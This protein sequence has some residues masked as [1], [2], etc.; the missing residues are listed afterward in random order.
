MKCGRPWPLWAP[1]AEGV[2]LAPRR[3]QE[4]GTRVARARKIDR[5]LRERGEAPGL[6]RR[7]GAAAS[8]HGCAVSGDFIGRGNEVRGIHADC[9]RGGVH[10]AAA[11]VREGAVSD[12]FIGRCGRG[13]R[14]LRRR[15]ARRRSRWMVSGR[16]C[17]V[18]GDFIGR[19]GR[20]ARDLRRRPARRG[21]RWMASGRRG[22]RFERLHRPLWGEVHGTCADCLRGGV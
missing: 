15:L 17:A 21:S 20:G 9:L 4:R 10:G 3:L 19:C 8:E 18:S 6:R 11:S 7:D 12:D 1:T 5:A 16:G 22:R 2:F 14:D 13:A